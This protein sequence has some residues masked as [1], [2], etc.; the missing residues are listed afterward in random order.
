MSLVAEV[1]V[2]ALAGD[3]SLAWT[4][5]S[6]A[7]LALQDCDPAASARYGAEL[8][9]RTRETGDVLSGFRWSGS[10]AV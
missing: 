9:W 2:A 5:L 4:R 1:S 6:R 3:A 8:V 10:V 7:E